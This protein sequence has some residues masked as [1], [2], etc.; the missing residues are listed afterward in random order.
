MLEKIIK[1]KIS[2]DHLLYVSLKYT[3]TC[4][5]I[6]NLLKRWTVMIN[7]SIDGLLAQLKKKKKIKSIPAAPRQKLELVKE[8]FKK[9]PE[10][11]KAMELYEFFKKVDN[12]K[13]IRESEFRKDVRLKVYDGV[14][15]TI[16]NL[17]KLKEYAA[18][19]ETF[20]SY[21]KQFLLTGK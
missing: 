11:M 7:D 8:Q 2:A 1:E 12:L 14:Q 10:I 21:V 17:D 6:I 16:I 13:T 20:I 5:V 4:D 19:L 18:I 9:T 15:E 3:K